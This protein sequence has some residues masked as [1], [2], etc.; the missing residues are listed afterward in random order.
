MPGFPELN[1]Q[2]P[3]LGNT[4]AVGAVFQLHIVIVAFIIGIAT[5]APLAEMMGLQAGENAARWD[6]LARWLGATII[7][8]FAF[9][10]TWAVFALVLLFGLYPR[11]F[12]VLT[13]RFFWPLLLV[14]GIWFVMTISAYL[15]AEAWDRV[16]KG[17]HITI[18]WV[19]VAFTFLFISLIAGLSSYQ[20]TPV[21]ATGGTMAL[22]NPSWLAEIIHRH[23]GN[24]S[25]AGLILAAYAGLRVLTSGQDTENRARY[26]W[27]GH[28][29]LLIGAG[30]VL[31]QPV[32][33][34]FYTRQVQVA[35][36]DAYYRMMIGENSWMFRI[37]T[38]LVGVGLF[39][40]NYYLM[41]TLSR[42]EGSGQRSAQ[43]RRPF[44]WLVAILALL[45]IVPKEW[46]LGQMM[47]WK[48]I[49]LVGLV[50][51]TAFNL[52]IYLR[53]MPAF[54]WGKVGAGP[55][56]AL[57]ALGVGIVALMITM[58]VIRE[59]ARGGDLIY[60]RLGPGQAQEL[61]LPSPAQ[62]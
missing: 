29:G 61:Q 35:S 36:Y 40:A 43:G 54:V 18:G 13:A 19:F 14:G 34:W 12:G 31:L 15:Y 3:I 42:M 38:L 33:G 27:A 23:I 6:W 45:A 9:G 59:S 4:W 56:V 57:I 47:P 21:E 10:A 39:L 2:V 37:Q 44:L 30:L 7:R 22:L 52:A 24:L 51:V 25:Y 28:L 5:I 41:T 53:N 48:Y 17:L 26:D 49:A 62:P 8:F 11:L 58:G 55:Q 32:V 16:G 50:I 1:L 60:K 46:P 20:L